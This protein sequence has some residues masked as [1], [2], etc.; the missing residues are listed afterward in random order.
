MSVP[1]HPDGFLAFVLTTARTCEPF[2]ALGLLSNAAR[3]LVYSRAMTAERA[4][5]LRAEISHTK[6]AWARRGEN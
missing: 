2:R 5:L 4:A 6:A 1:T 3:S